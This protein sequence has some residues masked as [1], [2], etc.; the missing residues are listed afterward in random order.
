MK[1]VFTGIL[2]LAGFIS[3]QIFTGNQSDVPVPVVSKDLTFYVSGFGGSK[4]GS[5]LY[6]SEAYKGILPPF[7]LSLGL[8]YRD[9]YFHLGY[10]QN[11]NLDLTL[12]HTIWNNGKFYALWG[13]NGLILPDVESEGTQYIPSES[14][15]KFL[16][17][18]FFAE[19]YMKPV[20][21]LEAG[22]GIGLGR[23]A[24][25]K[26]LEQP[27]KVPGFFATVAI[28]PVDFVK[29]YWE[30]YTSTWKRNLGIAIGPFK[31]IEFVT[32]FRYC[33]YPPQDNFFIQ[34]G[35]V[36]IRAE[37]PGEAIFKPAIS[38]VKLIIKEQATGK[39]VKGAQIVSTEGKF[40]TLVSNENGEVTTALKPGIYPFRVTGNSKYAP[41]SSMFEI[42]P[43]QKSVTVEIKLR[44][45]TEYMD[46][47]TILD[48]ARDLINKKDIK[49]AEIE[50]NKA[51]KLFPNDEEGLKVR[52][53]LYA[54]KSAMIKEISSR[55]DNYLRN[56]RYQD[57]IA[58]LQR[59]LT[60]DPQNDDVRKR[61]D[62]I[63]VVMLE[64]R[65]RETPVPA[66]QPVITPPPAAK[67]K[68]AP[69]EEQIS[70]PELIDR[71]KKLFFEGKYRDAKT[72]FEKAL[73]LEPNNKEAKFYLDKCESYIKMMGG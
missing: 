11:R 68:P 29:F 31:G 49:N 2:L 12:Q 69:K 35:F 18:P 45:S 36:G 32:A 7:G 53:S 65:K 34:Q 8:A 73:K 24:Q 4:L 22:I 40:P 47:L 46:Y 19:F 62:S 3:A 14:T 28:K 10:A 52:D 27:L 13:I 56:K 71:G 61:I 63:R 1:R 66:Q 59:I 55:A 58:E 67:P 48:R 60:F 37:I 70:V 41:L 38:E 57:A 42:Q 20:K 54:V 9:V 64:E 16:R 50:V 15:S 33:A 6:S 5:G 26:Y 72:Y 17:V 25:N 43:K 39:P 23:F 21:Y 51:L 44:Y 30:G